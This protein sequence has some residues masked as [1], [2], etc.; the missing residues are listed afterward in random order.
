[1]NSLPIELVELIVLYADLRTYR[2]LTITCLRYF[3]A[4]AKVPSFSFDSYVDS[5]RILGSNYTRGK[6]KL[7]LSFLNDQSFFYLVEQEHIDEVIRCLR[8]HMCHKISLQVK[9][10]AFKDV[11]EFNRNP[12]IANILLRSDS[13]VEP[14][15]RVSYQCCRAAEL[16]IHFGS[17]LH[18]ASENGLVGI[19]EYLLSDSRVNPLDFDEGGD[20]VLHAAAFSGNIETFKLLLNDQRISADVIGW[21]GWSPLHYAAHKGSLEIVKLLLAYPDVNAAALTY[22]H[23]NA[24][25]IAAKAATSTA[26]YNCEVIN[27]LL[28]DGRLDPNLICNSL[29]FGHQI[30]LHCA[31]SNGN[32]AA[33]KIL[34]EHSNPTVRDSNGI[35]AFDLAIYCGNLDIVAELRPYFSFGSSLI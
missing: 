24:L 31:I 21:K 9:Q 1:M 15:V 22:Y 16:R 26:N 35:H 12:E 8:S 2:N 6:M 7:D 23:G 30:P 5:I 10:I 17:P 25:H 19:V 4:L 29:E 27:L 33:F 20:S 11:I 18:W 34:L 14:H 13:R 28:Q 3:Q 32:I